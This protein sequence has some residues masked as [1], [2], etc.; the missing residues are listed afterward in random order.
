M[1]GDKRAEIIASTVGVVRSYCAGQGMGLPGTIPPECDGAL[2]DIATYRMLSLIPSDSLLTEVRVEAY[3]EAMRF[4][5][6]IA[7]G[8]ATITKP[9]PVSPDPVSSSVV[10]GSI[11]APPPSRS[12]WMLDG[13]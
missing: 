11:C 3:R 5:R 6:D 2:A 13:S 12:L 1:D 7:S 4:L 9:D 8:K 10:G